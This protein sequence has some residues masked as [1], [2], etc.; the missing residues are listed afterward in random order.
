[1]VAGS[2]VSRSNGTARWWRTAI[3]IGAAAYALV[4]GH[5]RVAW[6]AQ[7]GNQADAPNICGQPVAP[8]SV[9]P[10]PEAAPV[11]YVLGLCFP[12]QG[13]VSVIDPATYL[14]YIRLRTSRPSQ[15]EWVT[16]DA[17]AERTI[18]ADFDR[19][20]TT[21]F[22]DD[23][24]I[25]ASEYT[26]ANGV[27]GRLITYD[28]DERQR[29]RSVRYESDGALDQ[30]RI[31]EALRERGI[32]LRLDAFLDRQRVARARTVLRDLMAERGFADAEV[33]HAIEEMPGSP[34][35]VSITFQV[36]RG[37]RIA[38]RDVEFVGN[39]AV[40]EGALEGQLKSNRAQQLFSFVTRTGHYRGHEFEE[41]AQRVEDFY[42]DRGFIEARVGQPDLRILDDSPDGRTRWIQLRIP[43]EEGSR[44]R[45]GTV[46]FEGNQILDS[47]ALDAMFALEPGAWYSQ[48]AIRRG[49]ERA[50][51][52]YGAAGYME[53]TG[54]PDLRPRDPDGESAP[55]EP[56]DAP[57][58]DVVL[59]V[60]EGP[61][62]QVG[63]VSFAG[64]ATTHDSVIRREL[65]LLEGD[66]FSTAALRRASAAS[67]SWTTSSR[68]RGASATCGWRSRRHGRP[69]WT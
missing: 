53:F 9:L 46:G 15:N 64:N 68:W 4:A 11:L 22:L 1:M 8:P 58:V 18:L 25:E 45:I 40:D 59:H 13:N 5:A 19:L 56:G 39:R 2:D 32:E 61:R 67:T 10:P 69:R 51:D 36:D 34:H 23:L 35:L 54:F 14:H 12:T 16:D 28:L 30:S 49:L 37:P 6:A 20:W 33:G 17:E 63:R 3:V 47:A 27:A 50:R 42:R 29:I 7:D 48:A 26:F 55:H 38:I 65:R 44:Y 41:D 43:I 52:V 66:V 60:S 57:V 62:Y 24:R 31:D 21:G